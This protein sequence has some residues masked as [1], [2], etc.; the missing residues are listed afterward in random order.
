MVLGLLVVIQLSCKSVILFVILLSLSAFL[1]R[2]IKLSVA[3]FRSFLSWNKLFI[4]I[5][6]Q[7]KGVVNHHRF[8]GSTLV[9]GNQ[10]PLLHKI[11]IDWSVQTSKLGIARVHDETA[12]AKK[13]FTV[14]HFAL[15]SETLQER[16][17]G[18]SQQ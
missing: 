2:K 11:N 14:E 1:K 5:G 12:S 7:R 3:R 9:V 6:K 13:S 17:M 10:C 16:I 15:R 8:D 18:A 4:V